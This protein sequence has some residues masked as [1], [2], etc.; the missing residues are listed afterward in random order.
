MTGPHFVT[1]YPELRAD[2]EIAAL[3]TRTWVECADCIEFAHFG[4][5]EQA[6]EWAEDHA[7]RRGHERFRVVASTNFHVAPADV[8]TS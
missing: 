8:T 5:G 6:R 3:P 1:P 7:S 2:I 4:A